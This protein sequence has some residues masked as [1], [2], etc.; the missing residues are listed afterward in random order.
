[1]QRQS[2]VTIRLATAGLLMTAPALLIPAAQAAPL[3]P[4]T[5]VTQAAAQGL[6]IFN[7]DKFG[8]VRT[9]SACHING[10]TT[11]GQVPGG[12]KIPSLMGVA[13]QFPRY[14]PA[15]H[16]VVTLSTQLDHCI[17]GGLQGKAPAAN[18]VAMT[19]LITY[20]TKLSK[21]SVMGTQF[22]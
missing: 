12:G 21:G 15:A 7:H 6:H 2:R 16:Q 14:N 1:M 22:K 10:G 4:A 3:T 13:A 19:D 18:S 5:S 8:G 9:C 20:L 11:M 17:T